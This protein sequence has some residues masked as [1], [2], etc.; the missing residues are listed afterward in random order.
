MSYETKIRDDKEYIGNV[1][2]RF[3]GEYFTLWNPDS[4]LVVKSTYKNLVGSLVLNPTTIDPKKVS[5][6]IASYSVKL[7]DVGNV[8]SELV[9]LSGE[10]LVG[11]PVDIWLGRVKAGAQDTALD[12]ADYF[13][14]PTTRIK[15]ISR[16]DNAYT[17][18]TTEETDR[19]NRPIYDTKTRLSGTVLAA[20]TTFSVKD[21]IDDFP[22]SGFLKIRNEFVGYT[23]K[24]NTLKTFTG[25][26]RGEFSTLPDDYDDNEAVLIAEQVSGNPITTILKILIS[27]GGGGAYDTLKDGLGIDPDLIDLVEIEAIRDELFPNV[28]F[29]SHLYDIDSALNELETEFLAPLNLRF[30]YS[31]DS[32]LTLAVLDKARFVDEVDVVDDDT[33]TSFPKWTVNDNKITNQ[34]EIDWDYNEATAKY[35]QRTVFVDDD[36]VA[37][38][39]KKSSLKL[40]F[41]SLR[42]SLSGQDFVNTFG[43]ALLSRLSYPIPEIEVSTQIDKS[44]LNIGDKTLLR[45]SN[46]PNA[47]GK[48]NFAEEMEVISRSI[49]Y[50]TGD[51]KLK[52][53]F[54]SFTGVRS[55]YIAPSDTIQVVTAQDVVEVGA[56]KGDLWGVGWKVKLWD[57]VAHE[58]TAD[59]T[60]EIASIDGDEITFVDPWA[61]TLI[62]S[63]HRL[64][65]PF[66][67]EASEDQK[68]YCFISPDGLDFSNSE[69]S[70][71]IVP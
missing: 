23:A 29:V 3:L 51:V 45:S 41:K 62:A 46:L 43:A 39:G 33:V 56:G 14:L 31:K 1:V 50:Q 32:K 13:K 35:A 64:K 52:L 34:I 61:T 16:Q 63:Q 22:A 65:F 70:Y 12:F 55:C 38:Y 19:M 57:N 49:N 11:Q 42:A 5:T 28:S 24:D 37:A 36:S 9:K 47:S 53:A 30:T 10:D 25:L 69:K 68:R 60:N 67:D 44:L 17:F 2:V 15:E 20:T 6:T 71:K 7:T 48:L 54:T 40:K 26:T 27:N 66:F 58:Y 59:A 8:I 21:A 4:G 18:K